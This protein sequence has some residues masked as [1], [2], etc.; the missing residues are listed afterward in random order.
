[1]TRSEIHLFVLWENS[2]VAEERILSD[3]AGRVTVLAKIEG[4]WPTGVSAAAGFR[5]FYGAFLPDADEKVR[6]AG[7]GRFLIVVV[8]DE[9]A[10]YGDRETVRGIE[11]VNE[12]IFDMKWRYREWVGGGHRVHGTNSTDEARRDIMLLTGHPLADWVSGAAKGRPMTVLPGQD[13]W[14]SMAELFAFM[15]ETHPYVVLRNWEGLPAAFDPVHDDVDLLVANAKECAGLL[16]ARKARGG[17]AAYVVTVGG[18]DVHLDIRSVGDGYYD[19]AWQNEIL[20]SRVATPTGVYRPAALDAFHALYHHAVYQKRTLAAD[21]PA[22]LAALA[23]EAG[24]KFDSVDGALEGH[25][26]FLAERHYRGTE[27]KDKSMSVDLTLLDWRRYA[28][29]A[30]RICAVTEAR[31]WGLA[32][33]VRAKGSFTDIRFAAKNAAGESVLVKYVSAHASIVQSEYDAAVRFEKACPRH[34]V[35][36]LYWHTGRRGAYLVQAPHAGRTLASALAAGAVDA[37]LADRVAAAFVE[38][39]EGL[40][41]AEIVHRDVRPEKI[42]LADDGSVLLTGFRYGVRRTKYKKEIPYYRKRAFTLLAGLNTAFNPTPGKWLD[43]DAFE[44]ML[45]QLPQ[46]AAVEKALI[47]IKEL[48]RGDRP[49]L[50]KLPAASKFRAF[51]VW[52]KLGICAVMRPSSRYMIKNRDKLRFSKAVVFG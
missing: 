31:P 10:V 30:S 7:G 9:D 6:N 8:R 14:S 43:A 42:L 32:T 38:I 1:M 45:Q 26:R 51:F 52:V 21:Y 20:A 44:R 2:R 17:D 24:V 13:G 5:R 28:R 22:K 19:E 48:A 34:A 49:L 33:R 47:R 27:P 29:E 35:R 41:A 12:K 40:R 23:A 16:G 11:R 36:Q 25:E 39:A 46:T 18:R 37:V 4:G 3:M 50:V 15:S